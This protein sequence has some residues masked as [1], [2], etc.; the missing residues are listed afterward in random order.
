MSEAPTTSASGGRGSM[1]ALGGLLVLVLGC[2]VAAGFL[3]VRRNEAATADAATARSDATA[4][5]DMAVTVEGPFLYAAVTR[6][7]EAA[8]TPLDAG[9]QARAEVL[10]QPP[11]DAPQEPDGLYTESMSSEAPGAPSP[12]GVVPV[13]PA[14]FSRLRALGLL[15]TPKPSG[16][17]ATS[18]I[19]L[20]EQS[21]RAL[22]FARGS[23]DYA[24]T[25]RALA[26][27]AM[28][29]LD[30]VVFR[31]EVGADDAAQD[32]GESDA[33]LAWSRGERFATVL[34]PT[35]EWENLE[36]IVGMLNV[37]ARVRGSSVRFVLNDREG[38]AE[39]V[40]GLEPSLRAAV[41]EGLIDV[42]LDLAPSVETP[43]DAFLRGL[44]AVQ[45]KP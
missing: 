17:I 22:R 18:V 41:A 35:L 39:V 13:E 44:R 42:W 5:H 43:G 34:D 32:D 1:L 20:L 30:D 37:L 19:E 28:P 21:G 27:L 11:S 8:P 7:P 38:T 24:R 16:P 29:V 2:C 45:R 40:A 15:G 10:A 26:A 4:P 3:A 31:V 14:V 6:T 25:A 23:P 33:L 9:S 12:E 36:S